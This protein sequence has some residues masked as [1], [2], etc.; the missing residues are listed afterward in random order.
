M[1]FLFALHRGKNNCNI[2]LWKWPNPS[3]C[4]STNTKTT[5][6]WV[7]RVTNP[8]PTVCVEWVT[9]WCAVCKGNNHALI[10]N[11][12]H[13]YWYTNTQ[14]KREKQT[15][16]HTHRQIWRQTD[17]HTYRQIWRQTDIQTYTQ[18][19]MK[20]GRHEDIHT[21]RNENR[22]THTHTHIHAENGTIGLPVISRCLYM[23]MLLYMCIHS[24]A[25]WSHTAS[26]QGGPWRNW[27]NWN[28]SNWYTWHLA[29][30]LALHLALIQIISFSWYN[31]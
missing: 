21:D 24:I 18:T 25:Q 23:I 22:Q 8:D 17:I 9:I 28:I 7:C 13:T 26:Q 10:A 15:D 1:N 20:T 4:I 12:R 11:H 14:T 3:L 6:H 27:G 2:K 16:I 19:D 29:H 30:I 31:L 5:L